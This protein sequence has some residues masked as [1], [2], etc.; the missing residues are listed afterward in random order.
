MR[1]NKSAKTA[2]TALGPALS[3]GSVVALALLGAED[4]R[5]LGVWVGAGVGKSDGTR[6]GSA[7][8]ASDGVADGCCTQTV[9]SQDAEK[10][11]VWM[12]GS[13]KSKTLV[14]SN[15]AAQYLSWCDGWRSCRQW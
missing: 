14:R 4:G 6:V 13:D 1:Q 5:L 12:T 9:E 2:E 7:V 11:D 3:D 8:G 15:V 10:Y